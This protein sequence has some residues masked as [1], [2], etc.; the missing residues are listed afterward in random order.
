MMRRTQLLVVLLIAVAAPAAAQQLLTAYD[1]GRAESFLG[2]Y[3]TPLVMGAI[4]R[5]TWLAGGR[6]WYRNTIAE[7]AE[8]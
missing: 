7:G 5:P 1:Y 4:V 8:F 2:Q 6:F 3:T